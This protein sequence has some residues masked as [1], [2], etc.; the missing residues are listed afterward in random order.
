MPLFTYLIMA[1]V[2]ISAP[3]IADATPRSDE[4]LCE[5]V[6]FALNESVT[7]GYLTQTE[8]DEISDRCYELFT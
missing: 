1:T 6:A 2:F 5:E 7:L 8:A 4:V 3:L